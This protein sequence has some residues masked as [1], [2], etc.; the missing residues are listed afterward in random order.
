MLKKICFLLFPLVALPLACTPSD[1]VAREDASTQTDVAPDAPAD[2]TPDAPPSD[3]P[4]PPDVA[5]DAV[6]CGNVPMPT[7][8]LCTA[9]MPVAEP[10]CRCVIG[11]YW[12]GSACAFLGGCR[13]TAGCERVYPTMEACAAA[14]ATCRD[15]GAAADAG[16]TFAC[17]PTLRCQSGRQ[18]CH[19]TVPGIPG[20]SPTY[21]CTDLPA[22]CS[23]CTCVPEASTPGTLCNDATPGEINVRVL[24]P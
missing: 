21:R 20:A 17:G 19:E 10:G 22:G 6:Q 11:A 15:G 1:T 5:A 24:L 7:S 16:A 12:N 18:Y 3:V 23:R 8:H 2:V 14:H 13:C 4:V 9:A